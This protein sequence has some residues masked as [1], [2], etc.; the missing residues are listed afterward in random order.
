MATPG[1]PQNRDLLPVEAAG[2]G[3]GVSEERDVW[4]NG[5]DG[6][7]VAE[8]RISQAGREVLKGEMVCGR[9]WEVGLALSSE[10]AGGW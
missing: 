3:R 2:H 1:V 4:P 5:K 8:R 6:A 10:H 9:E 7:R